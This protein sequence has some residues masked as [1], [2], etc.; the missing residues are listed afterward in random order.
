MGRALEE[1]SPGFIPQH[2]LEPAVIVPVNQAS[3][4]GAMGSRSKRSSSTT[5]SVQGQPGLYETLS[6]KVN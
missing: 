4:G 2:Y 6:L 1:Q 3:G 5:S